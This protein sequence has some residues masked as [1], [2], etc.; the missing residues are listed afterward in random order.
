MK[1][2]KTFFKEAKENWV[3]NID[4]WVIVITDVCALQWEDEAG[5]VD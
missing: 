3:E 2:S 4:W 1:T 5:E